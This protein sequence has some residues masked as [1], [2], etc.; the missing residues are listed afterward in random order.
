MWKVV[1]LNEVVDSEPR[2]LPP[3]MAARLAQIIELI[4]TK[5]LEQLPRNL[6][7]HLD[8]KLGS[9]AYGAAMGLPAQST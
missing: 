3:P 5:G 9:F 6:S 7:R 1:I 2:A 8:D 4:E